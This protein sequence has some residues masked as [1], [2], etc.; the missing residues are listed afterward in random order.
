MHIILKYFPDLTEKQTGQF[1]RL[2][3]L[4]REW[5]SK[6]NVISRKDIEHLYERHVLHSLSIARQFSFKPGTRIIDIGTGGGFPGIPLAIYFPGVQITLA[7]SIGKKIRV[8]SE[9]TKELALNNTQCL[10]IRAEEIKE[11][12]DFIVSRAVSDLP[13][14]CKRFARLI[15]LRSINETPNGILYLKGGE[16]N[17]ELKQFKGR[18]TVTGLNT[19]FSEPFFETKKLVYIIP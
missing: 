11:T 15:S 17:R 1:S 16:L 12:F 13:E 3:S 4:Y 19:Y 7:D 5:N 6:I 14:F 18:Y 2:E 10:N 8:V 9:I